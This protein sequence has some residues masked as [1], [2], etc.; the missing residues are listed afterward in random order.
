MKRNFTNWL[1]IVLAWQVACFMFNLIGISY[2]R[3]LTGIMP[4]VDPNNPFFVYSQ[5]LLPFLEA[6]LFGFLFGS[7]FYV[8]YWSTL[9]TSFRRKSFGQVVAIQTVLYILA[10]SVVFVLVFFIMRNIDVFP[11]V[12]LEKFKLIITEYPHVLIAF[13]I[14]LT[15]II[16]IMSFFLEISKKFGPGNLAKLFTGKYHNPI[17]ENKIFM[18]LDLK[19]STTHAENLGHIKYSRLLQNCFLDINFIIN[20]YHA[21][22]YQYVGDEVVLM[23]DK[24]REDSATNCVKL[25]YAFCAHLMERSDKY[26]SRYGFV[27]E[28]KA[29]INQGT[30]TAAEVGQVKREIAFHGDVLNTAARIQMVCNQYK[31][32]LLASESFAELLE[33]VSEFKKV[34]IGYVPLKGKSIPVNV[35]SIEPI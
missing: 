30:V 24:D 6:G 21:E 15:M 1:L 14:Y 19:D 25:Y 35:Y 31:K 5:S 11:I 2:F 7:L 8:I 4:I 22:I 23:W 12:D 26:I 18:F 13:V 20:E 33:E 29:G 3:T 10:F 32:N 9:N 28:F 17:A 16:I 27:P 34:L